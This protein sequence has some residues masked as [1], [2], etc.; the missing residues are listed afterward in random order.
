MIQFKAQIDMINLE[1]AAPEEILKHDGDWVTVEFDSKRVP[2]ASEFI[3]K[4]KQAFKEKTG[5]A[6]YDD[7]F[8]GECATAYVDGFVDMFLNETTDDA[9]KEEFEIRATA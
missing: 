2:T 3:S 9:V 7:R 4:F 6:P 8:N 1:G 5:V